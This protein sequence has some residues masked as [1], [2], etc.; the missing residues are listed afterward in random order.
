DLLRRAVETTRTGEGAEVSICDA[1]IPL[2]DRFEKLFGGG[3]LTH[4][5]ERHA[6]ARNLQAQLAD[7]ASAQPPVAELLARGIASLAGETG[8]PESF[9]TLH[10]LLE[11]QHYRLAYWRVASD[12]INYRRFFSINDLAGIR[13]EN[14]EL[15]A[16]IHRLVARL[17]T[18]GKLHGLRIDHIDGLFDP[19]EY[20]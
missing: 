17:V 7:L 6:T 10:R 3:S 19:G 5:A 9:H 4:V 13:V 8:D 14:P 11:R 18:E 15:F 20:F 12:E 16:A 1:L 2:A